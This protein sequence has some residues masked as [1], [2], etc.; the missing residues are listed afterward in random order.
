MSLSGPGSEERLGRQIVEEVPPQPAA[1][2]ANPRGQTGNE[3][4]PVGDSAPPSGLSYLGLRPANP[5]VNLPE[6][7]K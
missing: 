3:R 1:A 6:D 7:V 4:V 2:P 5:R